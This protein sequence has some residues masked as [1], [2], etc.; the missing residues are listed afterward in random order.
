MAVEDNGK[1]ITR[2]SISLDEK[3]R[4]NIRIA[5]AFADQE[6]GQW[7]IAVLGAAAE[8]GIPDKARAAMRRRRKV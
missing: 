1:Q 2:I 7:C 3:T 8:R 6:V 5:A 4:K